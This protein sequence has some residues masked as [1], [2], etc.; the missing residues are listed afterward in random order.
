VLVGETCRDVPDEVEGTAEEMEITEEEEVDDASFW[1]PPN[2]VGRWLPWLLCERYQPRPMDPPMAERIMMP[3]NHTHL[4]RREVPLWVF[5]NHGLFLCSYGFELSSF[6]TI[7]NLL[8]KSLFCLGINV[9]S[10]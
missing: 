9:S 5:F 7:L 8:Q 4:E 1:L 3:T 6:A 10:D 2:E